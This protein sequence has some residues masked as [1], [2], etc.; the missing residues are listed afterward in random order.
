METSGK[1]REFSSG[2]KRDFADH[3]PRMELL[4]L[5]LLERVAIWYGLGA[6]KYGDNNW[7]KGQ[8]QSAVF[9]SLMRHASKYA[10]GDRTEDH[11]SAIVWNALCLINDEEYHAENPLICDMTGWFKDNKPT[12][13]G[14]CT[15]GQ[16]ES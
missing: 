12:G 11:L 5:D 8:P 6:D 7:R 9:G 4:P 10:K 14:S 1:T 16:Q 15:G 2:S 13:K 3:K